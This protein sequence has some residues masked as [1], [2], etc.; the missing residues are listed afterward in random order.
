M[1]QHFDGKKFQIMQPSGTCCESGCSGCELFIYKREN[2]LP[3]KNP[4]AEFFRN[5]AKENKLK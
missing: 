2:N 3:L 5:W 1:E 4:R